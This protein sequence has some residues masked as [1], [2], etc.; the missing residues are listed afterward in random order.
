[1]AKIDPSVMIA[2]AKLQAA[3]LSDEMK[4]NKISY[5]ATRKSL[6]ALKKRYGIK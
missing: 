6:E 3:L 5:E 4:A 1:M 2:I